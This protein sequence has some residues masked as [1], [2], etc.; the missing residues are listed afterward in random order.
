MERKTFAFGGL[1]SN[2]PQSQYGACL[3][4]RLGQQNVRWQP[5]LRSEQILG[6]L[7]RDTNGP[8]IRIEIVECST[9][10]KVGI[11]NLE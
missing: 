5:K 2:E 1:T 10:Y 8:V 4:D 6:F 3:A 11:N 9:H 7:S